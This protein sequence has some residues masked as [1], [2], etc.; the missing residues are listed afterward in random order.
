[1]IEVQGA[2]TIAYEERS[3][4]FCSEDCKNL[5]VSDPERFAQL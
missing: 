1:V 4:F 2:P 3:Y 5:F